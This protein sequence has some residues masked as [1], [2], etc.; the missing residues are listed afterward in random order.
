MSAVD[1]ERLRPEDPEE[2]PTTGDRRG[3]L[4]HTYSFDL[5]RLRPVRAF[6]RNRYVPLVFQVFMVIVFFYSIYCCFVGDSE[7]SN[8]FGLLMFWRVFWPSVILVSVVTVGLMW[9]SICPLGAITAAANRFGLNRPFPPRLRN[10]VI[11]LALWIIVVWLVRETFHI[12]DHG[13]RTAWFFILF[14]VAAVVMGRTFQNRAFCQYVCPIRIIAGLWSMLSFLELRP[15]RERCAECL[16]QECVTGNGEVRGCPMGLH[17]GELDSSRDCTYCLNCVKSCPH[18]A[19][20]IRLRCPGTEL[21]RGSRRLLVDAGA[22]LWAPVVLILLK[23]MEHRYTPSF[24]I[25]TTNWVQDLLGTANRQGIWFLVVT[26]FLIVTLVGAHATASKMASRVLA[27]DFR[28]TFATFS[29]MFAPLVLINIG[30]MSIRHF[31]GV[32]WGQMISAASAPLGIYSYRDPSL[33]SPAGIDL[34]GDG[35]GTPVLHGIGFFSTILLPFLIVAYRERD[36][37]KIIRAATP[38]ALIGFLIAGYFLWSS[39]RFPGGPWRW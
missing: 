20:Q 26:A 11:A 16:T 12:S 2:L 6:V 38:F 30:S 5:L 10:G 4:P 19:I 36:Q 9:C 14:I 23:S 28:R 22:L 27:W 37:R 33:L 8:N 29:Y 3:T 32:T 21:V 35:F 39:V 13:P 31:F 15:R 18:E 34:I 24:L 7:R 1:N 25:S 17:P